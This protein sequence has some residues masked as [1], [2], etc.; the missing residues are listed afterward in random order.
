MQPTDVFLIRHGQ[1]EWNAL[2]RFQG[3]LNSNLSDQGVAQARALAGHTVSHRLAHIYTS[4]LDRAH[5]TAE[6]VAQTQALSVQTDPRLGE[7]AMGVFEGNTRPN[8]EERFPAAWK[9]YK[10]LDPDYAIQGGGESIHHVQSRAFACLNELASRHTGSTI[11]CVSHG[12][13]IRIVLK[14][15]LG[16]PFETETRFRV[17]NTSVHHLVRDAKGWAV[18]TLGSVVHLPLD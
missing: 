2:G 1:T 12:G 14:S 4:H 9:D 16:I 7:R 6:I 11:G 13:L 3:Q 15:I 18:E 17:Q 10:S 5:Q 8:I